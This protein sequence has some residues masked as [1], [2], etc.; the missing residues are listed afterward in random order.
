MTMGI[1]KKALLLYIVI[2]SL[3]FL[4]YYF[5]HHR[6]HKE[7]VKNQLIN[8]YRYLTGILV[9]SAIKE[10]YGLKQLHSYIQNKNIHENVEIT[11]FN[12]HGEILYH[13]EGNDTSA[14]KLQPEKALSLALQG[15]PSFSDPHLREYPLYINMPVENNEFPVAVVRYKIFPHSEQSILISSPPYLFLFFLIVIPTLTVFFYLYRVLSSYHKSLVEMVDQF[16]LGNFKSQLLLTQDEPFYLLSGKIKLFSKQM[17]HK[18][19][20]L[21]TQKL[22]FENIAFSLNEGLMILD[23]N[24]KL[25]MYNKALKSILNISQG[26]KKPYWKYIK[27][28][29]LT[30]LLNNIQNPPHREVTQIR[31]NDKFY[32]CSAAYIPTH[33]ISLV[34]FYDITSFKLLED[35][36]KELVINVS[37][38]LRTPLTAIKGYTETLIEDIG[39]E[40]QSHL[41]IIL[42]HTDRMMRL[43]EDM[44]LLGRLEEDSDKKKEKVNLKQLIQDL[45][46][47]FEKRLQTK[48][49]EYS[50]NFPE[51]TPF[52]K[53][54]KSQLE[55]LF[56]N[57]IDNALKYTDKGG[58]RISM[59][60]ESKKIIVE[61]SDTG[62]GIP[63]QHHQRIFERFFVVN[64]ARSRR[65]GGTGLGLSIVKHIV[66]S[67]GGQIY[68]DS[69]PG[70]GTSFTVHFPSFFLNEVSNE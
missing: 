24:Q 42:R 10:E 22:M 39:Q 2:T 6:A 14:N 60:Q 65:R 5:S 28:P 46:P 49:L 67:H 58:I 70:K 47:I 48:K 51:K 53:G 63:P 35:I 13:T 69:T 68:V 34:L 8:H 66:L 9:V 31:W 55:Q 27:S 4:S 54:D 38:E 36:K 25:L 3:L 32:Y 62:Q 18:I 11:L 61:I 64:K 23:R 20:E 21:S 43:I 57:L 15:T 44:M 37:H 26:Q 29:P 59:H 40:Y 17:N 7:K 19:K 45:Y 12:K 30:E 1:W 16:L 50:V 33:Q 56:I 41:S 52:I